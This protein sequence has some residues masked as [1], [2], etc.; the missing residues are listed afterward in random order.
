[1][2]FYVTSNSE[3]VKNTKERSGSTKWEHYTDLL[4]CAKN[5]IFENKK[6]TNNLNKQ[7]RKHTSANNCRLLKKLAAK[8]QNFPALTKMTQNLSQSSR[9]PRFEPRTSRTEI[10]KTKGKKKRTT[11]QI[12]SLHD[13]T[14]RIQFPDQEGRKLTTNFFSS[15][16]AVKS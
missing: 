9:R 8:I 15:H 5:S 6:R 4:F 2:S 16:F 11:W 14:I 10:I 1:V 13:A 12:R 3:Q 7:N